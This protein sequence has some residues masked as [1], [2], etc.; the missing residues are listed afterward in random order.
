MEK[1]AWKVEGMTCTNCALTINQY[2]QKKGMSDAKVNFIGGEVTF[3]LPD[4]S[5]KV[6]IAKGIEDL[7]YHI[8]DEP[9]MQQL[10]KKKESFFQSSPAIRLLPSFYACIIAAHASLAFSFFNEPMDS[11]GY[12]CT[13][14]LGGDGLFWNQCSK[15]YAQRYPQH[16]CADRTGS[17]CCIRI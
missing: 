14:L 4:D 17:Y 12:L 8:V 2:L 3:T 6:S 11:T 9:M 1:V 7:G 5:S 10:P 15:K 13:G 16:E